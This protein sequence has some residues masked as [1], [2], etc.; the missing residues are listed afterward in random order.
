MIPVLVAIGL[1]LLQVGFTIAINRAAE[2]GSFVGLGAML[3][4]VPAIPATAL[5]NFVLVRS[6]RNTGSSRWVLRVMLVSLV[7]P[8][9]QLAL[10]L[11][12][13]LFRL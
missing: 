6:D 12:V 5:V 9:A 7:L 1:A 3:L 13:S 10:L 4:A 8:V 2:G 11:L